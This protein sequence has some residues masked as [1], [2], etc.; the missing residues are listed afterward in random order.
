MTMRNCRWLAASLALTLLGAT[1]LTG[2]GA[3]APAQTAAGPA[4]SVARS[5]IRALA[6]LEPESG[7]IVL[8]ARPGARLV[9]VAAAEGQNVQAGELLAVLEGHDQRARQLALAEAQREAARFLRRLRR[10][11]LALERARFDRLKQP[12]LESLR[13]IVTDLKSKVGPAAEARKGE[14][15]GKPQ[16]SQARSAAPALGGG[17]VPPIV[18]DMLAA[19]LRTELAKS[20]LQLKELEVSL[21][22][23]ERQRKLEDEQAADDAPDLAVLDRQVELARADLAQSEV[24]APVAGKVL[25]VL[26]RAGE[27]S[28]GPLLTMG[29]LRSM[30][31]R[32][33]VFQTDVLDIAPGDPAEVNILGQTVAGEVTRVGRTVVRNLI[34]SLD[35]TALAD[36]RVVEVVVRLTDPSLASRLVD[37]QVEVAIRKR[38]PG[39][40]PRSP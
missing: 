32:A 20:E 16:V 12:R 40:P 21:E 2:P 14:P 7:L 1:A 9:K 23:L 26:A 17:M 10:E 30:V 38:P 28:S 39:G 24:R 35:P 5:Q 34:T 19:Q 22:L 18:Q 36:R 13:S 15:D 31:A 3:S 6:R 33:E 8:G 37:M 27:V 4:S 25:A 11:Q 29:D